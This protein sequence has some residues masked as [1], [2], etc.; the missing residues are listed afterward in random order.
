MKPGFRTSE[1]TLGTLT[2]GGVYALAQQ[3]MS[4]SMSVGSGIA[5][6]GASLALAAIAIVYIRT[7]GDVKA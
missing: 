2:G 4:A 1:M 7:R 6:A 5:M 3:G